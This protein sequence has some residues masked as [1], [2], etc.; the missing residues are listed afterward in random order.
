MV[1]T[2]ATQPANMEGQM[3][4]PTSLSNS[5]YK[6]TLKQGADPLMLSLMMNHDENRIGS[7]D[8][9]CLAESFT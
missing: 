3:W 8:F 2:K 5:F 1:E 9:K 6:V 4:L 7:P